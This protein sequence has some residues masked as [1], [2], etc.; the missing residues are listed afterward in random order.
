MH[1]M[2]LFF[3]Y[4]RILLVIRGNRERESLGLGVVKVVLRLKV[5]YTYINLEW[6]RSRRDRLEC[7]SLVV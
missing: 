5:M 6:L 1:G 4:N 7:T 2:S 3:S